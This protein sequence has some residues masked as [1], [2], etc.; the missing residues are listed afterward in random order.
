MPGIVYLLSR[1]FI[2]GSPNY[3]RIVGPKQPRQ[4]ITSDLDLGN[5]L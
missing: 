5:S 4:L 1:I 2:H 3:T